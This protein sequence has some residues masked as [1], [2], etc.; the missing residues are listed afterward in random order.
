MSHKV[1]CIGVESLS[2]LVPGIN[3]PNRKDQFRLIGRPEFLNIAVAQF[4]RQNYLSENLYPTPYT[5]STYFGS[6]DLISI[7]RRMFLM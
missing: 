1:I 6:A 7:L 3:L 4:H 5:V 2:L